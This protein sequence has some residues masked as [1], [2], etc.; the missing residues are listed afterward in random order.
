M[1]LFL[2][3][4]PTVEVMSSR[5]VW[6]VFLRTW[7]LDA[8]LHTESQDRNQPHW[9]RL[10]LLDVGDACLQHGEATLKHAVLSDGRHLRATSQKYPPVSSNVAPMWGPIVS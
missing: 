1:F 4:I 7:P 3:G 9:N 10:R 6:L 2:G 8:V 5:L